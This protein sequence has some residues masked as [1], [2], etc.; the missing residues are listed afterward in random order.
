MRKG[1][2]LK[3]RRRSEKVFGAEVNET[4]LCKIARVHIC[5][6]VWGSALD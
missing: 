2:V 4:G 1:R 3:K 5:I 6:L